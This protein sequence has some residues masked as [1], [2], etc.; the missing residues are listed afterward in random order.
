MTDGEPKTPRPWL[1]AAVL[2]AVAATARLGAAWTLGSG[3]PF[4]PD[5][6]GAQA[7]LHLGGHPYPLHTAAL[8]L[9]QDARLLSLV[10]STALCLALWAWGRRM[11][12]G[13]AGGWLCAF[14]P[15][16]VYTGALSA[17]DAP[18]LFLVVFGALLA[19]GRGGLPVLGGALALASVAIKPIALPALVLLLPRPMAFV[20]VTLAVPMALRWLGPLVR[21]L[22]QG[23]LLGTWWVASGG[24]PPTD[25]AGWCSLIEGGVRSVVNAPL[26]A[27]TPLAVLALLGALW[28]RQGSPNPTVG[29]RLCSL[30]A[31]AGLVVVAALFGDRV[32]PRYLLPSVVALL[33]WAGALLPRSVS[34]VLLWPTLAL[35]TQVSAERS[36]RDP[37][38][39]VPE[40]PVLSLP[41]VDAR[42]LF[43]ESSTDGATALRQEAHRLAATLP[44]GA[45]VTVEHRAHDREGEL[46]WPLQ[47]LRPDVKIRVVQP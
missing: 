10:S 22:P 14:L 46:T 30:G 27:C 5:G 42:Q 47:V 21:P 9:T 1:A 32:E 45:T 7:S 31:V 15:G 37:A 4:G 23:G 2:L 12:L 41:R 38:A 11:G 33:P 16:A 6:T 36:A 28:P 17:G 18:A 13:G 8:H 40:L 20:G 39:A 25:A 29:T 44:E 43:D 3:A 26:W 19:T 35:L 34:W 24:T